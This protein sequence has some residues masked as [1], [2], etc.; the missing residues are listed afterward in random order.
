MERSLNSYEYW[1]LLQRTQNPCVS[2]QSS[3]IPAPQDPA[4]PS[5]LQGAA[6]VCSTDL[7][8]VGTRTYIE[9]L[10]LK[11]FNCL[12][13]SSLSF[14]FSFGSALNYLQNTIIF[15]QKK[16]Y[17]INFFHIQNKLSIIF[18]LLHTYLEGFIS[19]ST[20]FF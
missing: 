8:Q 20:K 2:S 1:L 4:L 5:G 19:F 15:R 16:A 17:G 3:V 12:K 10:N 7:L 6:H 18:K 13:I 14:M 9:K 11:F